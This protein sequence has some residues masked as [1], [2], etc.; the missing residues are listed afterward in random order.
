MYDC[1]EWNA[2]DELTL[3]GSIVSFDEEVKFKSDR[4]AMKYDPTKYTRVF[5]PEPYKGWDALLTQLK[6]SGR[7]LRD[8]ESTNRGRCDNE[9]MK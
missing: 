4:S 2:E 9:T 3:P 5:N 6:A 7:V 1:Q 8:S